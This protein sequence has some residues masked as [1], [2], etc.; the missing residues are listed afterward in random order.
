MTL[1]RS[2]HRDDYRRVTDEVPITFLAAGGPAQ[3]VADPARGSSVVL[4]SG[5][6]RGL[7][8]KWGFPA[9]FIFGLLAAAVSMVLVMAIKEKAKPEAGHRAK[10]ETGM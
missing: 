6:A 4:C 1:F 8:D 9:S 10:V 3:P 5:N 2:G 7:L